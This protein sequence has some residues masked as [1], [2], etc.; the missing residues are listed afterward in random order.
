MSAKPHPK[1]PE[2]QK[3]VQGVVGYAMGAGAI[4][5]LAAMSAAKAG[6]EKAATAES[7]R[8]SF[9]ICNTPITDL[10]LWVDHI[11]DSRE[12][13]LRT[14]HRATQTSPYHPKRALTQ[15]S[16]GTIQRQSRNSLIARSARMI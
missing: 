5:A 16:I 13:L 7:A 15:K 1:P 4:G 14:C 12:M 11:H 8:S 6:A 10:N 9:F 3:P 2:I